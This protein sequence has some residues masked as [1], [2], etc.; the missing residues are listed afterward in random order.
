MV[1]YFPLRNALSTGA[2]L[3]SQCPKHKTRI[4]YYKRGKAT[5]EIISYP[6]IIGVA[7][8]TY[9]AAAR[10]LFSATLGANRPK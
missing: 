5:V 10:L 2:D 9:F 3:L 6:A 1:W 4:L 7:I 8:T